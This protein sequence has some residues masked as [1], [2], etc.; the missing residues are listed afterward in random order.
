E[1]KL[2]VRKGCPPVRQKK[3]GQAV[4]RNVVINDEVGKLVTAGIMREV[5]YHDWLSNPVMVKKS[6][7]KYGYIKNHKKQSKT[8]KQGHENGRVYK[9][10]KQ[11]QEKSNPQS[12]WSNHGQQ[13]PKY[14][15]LAP[16]LSEKFINGP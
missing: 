12:K 11:S 10:R 8:S 16:H 6:D 4:E 9:S 7:D 1:H 13:D 3:R 5:H 15:T 14:S 2:N